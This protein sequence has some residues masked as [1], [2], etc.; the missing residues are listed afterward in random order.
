MNASDFFN[1]YI[2]GFILNVLAGIIGF[3]LIR[4]LFEWLPNS[5]DLSGKF[6]AVKQKANARDK[7]TA[8]TPL[9]FISFYWMFLANMLWIVLYMVVEVLWWPELMASLKIPQIT[10]Y[11]EKMQP[12][13]VAGRSILFV[14]GCIAVATCFYRGA[15]IARQ[16]WE[17]YR[18]TDIE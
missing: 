2:A 10:E 6:R 8:L 14:L 17:V 13:L 5:E 3:F 16:C 18:A 7:I 4:K 15:Q 9:I 11:L 1:T 12:G